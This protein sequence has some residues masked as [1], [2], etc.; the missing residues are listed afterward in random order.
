MDGAGR[1]V[2]ELVAISLAAVPLGLSVW[3]LLDIARRPAWA[4]ALSGRNRAMWLAAVLVGILSVIGGVII[5]GIYLLR[6][7]PRIAAT[8]AGHLPDLDP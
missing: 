4:W 1:I 5:S 2:G 6:I 7:R 3:A 8:E